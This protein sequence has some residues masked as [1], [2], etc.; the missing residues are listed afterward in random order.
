MRTRLFA[1]LVVPVVAVSVLAGFFVNERSDRFRA[2]EQAFAVAELAEQVAAL[3]QALGDETLAATR[4]ARGADGIGR[5]PGFLSYSAAAAATDAEVANV[6]ARLNQGRYHSELTGAV[7]SIERTLAFRSDV[8]GGR[9]SPLQILDRYS[10]IRG[11]LLDALAA[12]TL[13]VTSPEGQQ[14]LLVLVDLFEARSAHL[15]ERVAV[16]VARS[17]GRWAPGLQSAMAAS[18]AGQ[19]AHLDNANR[20]LFGREVESPTLLAAWRTQITF[21]NGPPIVNARVWTDL[22]DRWLAELTGQ[23][24]GQTVRT[25]GVL[26]QQ[27]AAAERVRL[28]ALVG[29]GGTVLLALL[30]ASVVSV[31]LVRRVSIITNQARRLAAGLDTDRTSPEVRGSDEL[32]QLAEAFD[33]MTSQ[34]ETRA[35]NQ[36]IESTVLESIVQGASVETVLDYAAPLLGVTDEGQPLYRFCS[37]ADNRVMVE[38][39]KAAVERLGVPD[40]PIPIEELSHLAEARTALGLALMARQRDADHHKLAWQAS[41]DE[42]TG[43]L[44]R[45]AIL[46]EALGLERSE[47]DDGPCPG[48]LYVILTDS[49]RSTTNSA[50]RQATGC[51]WPRLNG[52]PSWLDDLTARSAGWAAMSFCSSFP[53][54]WVTPTCSM[55]PT[56]SSPS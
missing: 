15:T 26:S 34:I 13:A 40:E 56:R 46:A 48:L 19:T 32:G 24:E 51:W 30:V 16:E 10:H 47:D 31:R 4:V 18:V 35:T 49:R 28:A 54:C 6:N 42:L 8:T 25:M 36:W 41:R 2:A 39:T 27:V 20:F 1:L 37:E 9:I 3:D 17:N 52:W 43:L 12:Q 22:S 23:I 29:A 50:T 5:A 45:G 53:T 38:P 7:E 55:W 11:L 33:E 21:S 14:G 44:N